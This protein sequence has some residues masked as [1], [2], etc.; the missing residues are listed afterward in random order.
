MKSF[1]SFCEDFNNWRSPVGAVGNGP[2]VISQGAIPTG[3]KGANDS[4][5]QVQIVKSPKGKLANRRKV[6]RKRR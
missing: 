3:F 4:S 2:D 6:L 5:T 1:K